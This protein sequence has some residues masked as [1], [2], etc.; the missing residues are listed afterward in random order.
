M[1]TKTITRRGLALLLGTAWILVFASSVAG[2]EEQ[3]EAVIIREF[4]KNSDF[5]FKG[6]VVSVDYR[7][8]EPVPIIDPRTERQAVE[9]G[10]PVFQDGSD[11]PH[12]FVTFFI[13]RIYKGKA[14]VG[15]VG[16]PPSDHVTLRFVGGPYP[17][18]DFEVIFVDT[19]PFFD[20]GDRDV[21]FVDRNTIKACPLYRSDP[22]PTRQEEAEGYVFRY[23][24]PSHQQDASG[25]GHPCA[26]GRT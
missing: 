9:D 24:P 25:F 8:S 15:T 11:L 23:R 13:E 20:E 17:Q 4:V 26:Q 1:F 21:L 12:T 19:Y 14:P 22:R 6:K 10:L 3:R 18:D 2:H 7:S 5:I 16:G